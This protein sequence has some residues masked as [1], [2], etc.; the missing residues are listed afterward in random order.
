MQKSEKE[1]QILYINTYMRNLE[2]MIQTKLFA[3]QK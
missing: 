1:K 3:M 2:K